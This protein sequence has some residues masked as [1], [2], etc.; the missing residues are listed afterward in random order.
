VEE[1]IELTIKPLIGSMAAE[2]DE[3]PVLPPVTPDVVADCPS[4]RGRILP[5]KTIQ[6]IYKFILQFHYQFFIIFDYFLPESCVKAAVS[7]VKLLVTPLAVD[8]ICFNQFDN[9]SNFD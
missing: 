4:V 5:S 6:T 7:E 1:L 9:K 8:E 3:A 2:A